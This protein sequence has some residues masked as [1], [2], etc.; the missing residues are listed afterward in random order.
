MTWGSGATYERYACSFCGGDD[1]DDTDEGPS[2]H[3][4]TCEE[5]KP[6][7]RLKRFFGISNLPKARVVTNA[8]RKGID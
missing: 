4:Q 7:R 5:R 3:A 1:C 2:T 8:S 6:L